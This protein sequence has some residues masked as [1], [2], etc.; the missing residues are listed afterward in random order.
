MTMKTMIQFAH[1]K[2]GLGKKARDHHLKS[3]MPPVTTG[4]NFAE[5]AHGR[6]QTPDRW[7]PPG[8]DSECVGRN[9]EVQ[10]GERLTAFLRST[11]TL[12]SRSATSASQTGTVRR[13]MTERVSQ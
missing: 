2:G 3:K 13:T 1:G 7:S 4:G 12:P 6:D 8:D 11:R 5:Q 9:H 10:R